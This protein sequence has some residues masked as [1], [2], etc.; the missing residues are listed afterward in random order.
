MTKIKPFLY[1]MLFEVIAVVM[2]FLISTQMQSGGEDVE[3]LVRGIEYLIKIHLII[4]VV[5]IINY[6]WA[7]QNVA[8]III[9]LTIGILPFLLK[10]FS[11]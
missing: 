6:K 7:K 1:L 4:I 5:P 8:F 2:I 3:F 9:C 11:N 10:L